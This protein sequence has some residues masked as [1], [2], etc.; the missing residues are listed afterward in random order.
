MDFPIRSRRRMLRASQTWQEGHRE[1][2]LDL[3]YEHD[4]PVTFNVYYHTDAG[5]GEGGDCTSVE[6]CSF[7]PECKWKVM[8]LSWFECVFSMYPLP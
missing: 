8:L 3:R 5:G 6:C 7:H 4:F 2:A 1:Q